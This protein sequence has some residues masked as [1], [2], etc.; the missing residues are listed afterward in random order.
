[1]DALKKAEEE[2]KKAAK[3]LEQVE[4]NTRAEDIG[5]DDPNRQ[6]DLLRK[7]IILFKKKIM[8]NNYSLNDYDTALIDLDICL[9]MHN[10]K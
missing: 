1:M 8:K 4:A 6:L 10:G 2:K 9:K 3:R 7:N 5:D